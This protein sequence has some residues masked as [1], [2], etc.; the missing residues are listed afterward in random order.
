MAIETPSV[1]IVVRATPAMVRSSRTTVVDVG[2]LVVATA[3]LSTSLVL[4]VGLF[5]L[6]ASIALLGF[7]AVKAGATPLRR[8]LTESSIRRARRLRRDARERALPREGSGRD[9]LVELTQ[10]VDQIEAD[11]PELARRID[12]EALLDR[13]VELGLTYERALRA[14]RL[15]NRIQL[16]RMR[17]SLRS[18]P[19]ANASRLE[20]CERRLECLEQC[21]AKA[22]QLADELAILGDMIRLIAQRVA[23]PDDPI[24]DDTI[25]HHLAEFD[26]D[27][28]ARRQLAEL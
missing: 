19:D 5:G 18:D 17:D 7:I 23:C 8:A 9:A 26:E 28:A 14:V 27:D 22:E 25:G 24:R 11:D 2:A 4:P 15:A 3:A 21:E 10:L 12:L 6:I 16:E 13:H 1:A 20:L